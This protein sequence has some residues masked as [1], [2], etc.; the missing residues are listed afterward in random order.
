MFFFFLRRIKKLDLVKT[1]QYICV[2]VCVCAMDE[3][4]HGDEER[5]HLYRFDRNFNT[6]HLVL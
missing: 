1:C 6:L 2:C 5:V 3:C 4:C